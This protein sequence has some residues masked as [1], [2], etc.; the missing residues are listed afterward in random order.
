ME[1]V[2][3]RRDIVLRSVL[4]LGL[5]SLLL[6]GCAS[7]RTVES[8]VQTFS[9]L[10][11]LP[12]Q[13]T[14]RFERLPSQQAQLQRQTQVEGMAEQ[15]LLQVG[16]RRDDVQAHY[17]V[18][19]GVRVEREDR[20]DWSDAWWYGPGLRGWNHGY[21]GRWPGPWAHTTPWYQR[22]VSLALRDNATGQVVYETHALEEGVWSDTAN[23]L[24]VLFRAALTDFPAA[25]KGVSQSKVA[26]P[27]H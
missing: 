18:Q 13:P 1:G 21:M 19:L 4:G 10:S 3:R 27:P 20:L 5:V 24:P 25:T 16:L 26:L 11:V 15:A 7:V 17:T 9:T 14:Y 8:E 6:A 2:N 23:L 12:A 22:E